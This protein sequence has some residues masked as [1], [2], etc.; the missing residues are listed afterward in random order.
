MCETL[1]QP[2]CRK[3]AQMKRWMPGVLST[4]FC[5]LM[6]STALAS[7]ITLGMIDTFE[8]GPQGWFTAGVQVPGQPATVQTGGPTGNFM[9]LS[10]T[11]LSGPGSRLVV[12][13]Q[14]QWTG[15]Y[16]AAGVTGI[17]MNVINLGLTDLYL[18]L[19]FEN[20]VAGPP[21]DIAFTTNAIFL[22]AGGGWTSATFM[23]NPG[24]LTAALGTVNA[25]LM[26]TT[27]LRLYHSQAP[28][29]PNPAFPITPI[30]AQL[31]VD[32]IAALG[33]PLPEPSSLLL[34][35]TGLALIATRKWNR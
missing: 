10:A 22:P 34:L 2:K 12:Q 17:S 26:N 20:P 13:N 27:L 1:F 19:A 29:V 3:E 16:I 14:S 5:I 18:R 6:T 9:L 33:A 25:A 23:I 28:N 11:G 21:T 15:N 4:L 32:N 30:S 31:G 35:G 24:N 7:P 8:S